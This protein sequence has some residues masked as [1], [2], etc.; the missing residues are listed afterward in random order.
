MKIV[1]FDTYILIFP[2]FGFIFGIT[3]I[4]WIDLGTPEMLVIENSS[5]VILSF[6]TLKTNPKP[7]NTT[8]PQTK[9]TESGDKSFVQVVICT[10]NECKTLHKTTFLDFKIFAVIQ[11]WPKQLLIN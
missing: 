11:A 2:K 3:D 8:N 5:E 7:Q 1:S 6:N 4:S 10:S 9:K